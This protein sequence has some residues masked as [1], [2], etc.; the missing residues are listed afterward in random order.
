MAAKQTRPTDVSVVLAYLV[1]LDDFASKAMML[2][3]TRLPDNRL[4]PAIYHLAKHKAI[5]CVV[6]NTNEL[7]WFATPERDTRVIVRKATAEGITRNDKHG[8]ISKKRREILAALDPV[9]QRG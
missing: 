4:R 9:R 1:G 3:A 5:D 7:W 8:R 6:V 2:E